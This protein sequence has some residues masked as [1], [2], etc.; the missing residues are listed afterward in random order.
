M[1]KSAALSLILPVLLL[2]ETSAQAMQ[3]E[4]DNWT[5][6]AGGTFKVLYGQNSYEKQ[7]DNTDNH[8]ETYSGANINLSATY[9]FTPRYQLGFYYSTDTDGNNYL[10]DYS[11]N[12]W[13]EQFYAALQSPY[14]EIQIGQNYNVAYLFYAG[15]PNAASPLGIN[16]SSIVNFYSNPNWINNGG[17]R[18]AYRTLNSTQLDTDNVATKFN[19]ISP[20]FHGTRFGFTYM[21]EAYINQGLINGYAPYHNEEA[22]VF[23][24]SNNSRFGDFIIN[25]YLGYGLYAKED[26]D[27]A[28]GLNITWKEWTLGGSFRR[29]NV[30]G[31]RYPVNKQINSYMTAPYFDNFRE[32]KAWNIGLSYTYGKL[33]TA[34]LYFE[35]EADLTQNQDKYIQFT[36]QYQYNEYL[37]LFATVAHVS[38][39][40]ADN[41]AA[42]SNKGYSY[43]TGFMLNI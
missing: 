24:L 17:K 8:N 4:Y 29:T 37:S 7:Y 30:D 36:N 16:D 41:T 12:E 10:N 6:N 13:D 39:T 21:P 11:P 40:G 19:Y 18:A 34:L 26:K 20:E 14:G 3:F 22:Y 43:I 28:A 31:N 33:T 42:D 2:S 38:F 35:T 15:A 27:Y 23:A 25:S 9:K 1:N 32:G 5:F